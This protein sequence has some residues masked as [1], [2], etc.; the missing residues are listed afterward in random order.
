MAPA[1][2]D[3]HEDKEKNIVTATSELT[4]VKKEDFLAGYAQ[5]LS[6]CC[7][8][9]KN[10]TFRGSSSSQLHSE[11]KELWTLVHCNFSNASRRKNTGLDGN[12]V[13]SVTFSKATVEQT[14]TKL[15]PPRLVKRK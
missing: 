2:M 9:H 11:R 1:R 4:S 14:R 8:N 15:R 5:R 12:G 3:L 10:K 7:C 13:L 6:D